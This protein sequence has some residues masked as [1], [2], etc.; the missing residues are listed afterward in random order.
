M[1]SPASQHYKKQRAPTQP[2]QDNN[3]SLENMMEDVV[4]IDAVMRDIEIQ[5]GQLTNEMTL[6]HKALF[7]DIL[8]FQKDK[9]KSNKMG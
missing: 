2:T 6:R 4:R 7:K 9:E 1:Q 5:V 3:T 8:K